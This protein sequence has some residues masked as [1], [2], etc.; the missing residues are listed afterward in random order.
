MISKGRL[1]D[2]TVCLKTKRP[3]YLTSHNIRVDKLEDGC[4][5]GVRAARKKLL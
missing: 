4:N 3:G 1:K 2:K 5:A